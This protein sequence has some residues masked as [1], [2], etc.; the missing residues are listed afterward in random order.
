LLGGE[1]FDDFFHSVI[2]LSDLAVL[3]KASLQASTK[4][5]F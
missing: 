2:I 5:R 3:A 1:Y 4:A